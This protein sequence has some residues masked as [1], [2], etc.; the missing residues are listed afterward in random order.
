MP[1][2]RGIAAAPRCW[3]AGCHRGRERWQAVRMRCA[4]AA[5]ATPP[6]RCRRRPGP[7]EGGGWPRHPNCMR[8]RTRRSASSTLMALAV[9]GVALAPGPHVGET[10]R[11][12]PQDRLGRVA[13]CRRSDRRPLPGWRRRGCRCRA[14]KLPGNRCRR[15]GGWPPEGGVL[16]WLNSYSC[17]Y[18]FW[19]I[20]FK[21]FFEFRC[22]AA[23][24][25]WRDR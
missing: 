19:A 5:S 1:P 17:L 8:S 20:F 15:R 11:S 7:G 13:V 6:P 24:Q 22:H 4:T 18:Q 12:R 10:G 14:P 2:D 9:A 21:R 3:R 16:G 25:G 23:F